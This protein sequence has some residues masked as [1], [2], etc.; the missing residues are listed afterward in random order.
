MEERASLVGSDV[1]MARDVAGDVGP[2]VSYAE[3]AQAAID[4]GE[5]QQSPVV[6][7]DMAAVLG[8][9]SAEVNSLD[10]READGRESL[11]VLQMVVGVLHREHRNTAVSERAVDVHVVAYN[12]QAASWSRSDDVEYR[13]GRPL[14]HLDMQPGKSQ[15]GRSDDLMAFPATQFE[16]KLHKVLQADNYA[17]GAD[18]YH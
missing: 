5:A 3:V 8:V 12:C 4:A 11:V 15:A 6:A 13:P 2:M 1:L 7:E 10:W 16:E 18:D 14:V 9:G 17:K